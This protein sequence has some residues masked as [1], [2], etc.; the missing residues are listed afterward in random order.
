MNGLAEKERENPVEVLIEGARLGAGGLR[1]LVRMLKWR[2]KGIQPSAATLSRRPN[3]LQS[4]IWM[5]CRILSR[6]SVDVGAVG[7]T[8]IRTR[9]MGSKWGWSSNYRALER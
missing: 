2:G 3:R 8:G 4:R 1:P 9:A 6:S 5:M 7:A